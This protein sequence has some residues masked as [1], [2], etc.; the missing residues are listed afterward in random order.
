MPLPTFAKAN[1]I[2]SETTSGKVSNGMVPQNEDAVNTQNGNVIPL[3]ER[4]NDQNNDI[5]YSLPMK[6]A[7]GNTVDSAEY[8]DKNRDSV[9]QD[10]YSLTTW[11][12]ST[13]KEQLVKTL[14]EAGFKNHDIR[15]W[16]DDVD[17]VAS[18]IAASK[19]LDYTA[20]N[21]ES[22]RFMRNNQEYF[23]TLDAS[24][25]CAKRLIYQGTFNAIQER[26]KNTPLLADDI[27]RLRQMM[28]EAM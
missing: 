5:R 4:F 1:A 2:T 16:M 20:Y 3:S 19:N 15:K 26:L 25:L 24:T 10:Q 9:A 14:Q 6:T 22:N 21:T 11:R 12:N 28:K 8:V 13:N 17:S 18:V 27:V 23:A 7:D